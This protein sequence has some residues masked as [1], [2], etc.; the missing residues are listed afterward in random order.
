MLRRHLLCYLEAYALVWATL[1]LAVAA[2]MVVA[3][4]SAAV[5]MLAAVVG[6]G[7][8]SGAIQRA[9]RARERT[10]RARAIHEIREMLRDQVLN[11]LSAMKMWVGET[12]DPDVVDDLFAEVDA[13]IDTVAVMIDRLTEEQLDT[14]KLTYAN[15]A[16][17]TEHRSASVA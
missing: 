17:H 13:G 16:H 7:G 5:A 3:D 8:I 9:N 14:W 6:M 11:Q 2:W 1:F 4:V 10:L 15:A 12:P